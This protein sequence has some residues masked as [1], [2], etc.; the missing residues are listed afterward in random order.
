MT[1]LYH[2]HAGHTLGA[3]LCLAALPSLANEPSPALATSTAASGVLPAI[4]VKA[5]RIPK[6]PTSSQ[7]DQRKG[8]NRLKAGETDTTRLIEQTPGVSAYS[9]GGLSS[10]PAIHGLADD[11]VRVQV[12]GMD[13]QAACPNHMNSALSYIAPANVGEI[14]VYAGITPVSAGGDSLGGSIQVNQAA[15]RFA[16][17]DDQPLVQGE[18][19][20]SLRS[21]GRAQSSQLSATY[22]T[23]SLSLSY[24]GVTG[25]ADNYRAARGFKPAQ[26]GTEGGRIIP[27]DEVASSAY[28]FINQDV[29]LAW[30]HD[31]HLLELK[32][33]EQH[34]L[35]EGFPNQRMDMTGNR[36]TLVNLHY[37]G[38]FAWGELDARAYTQRTHHTMDMGPDRYQYGTGM[39]MLTRASTD[40]LQL[41]A[42]LQLTPQD[43]LRV[44]SEALRYNLYDWWP[45]VGGAMGPRAFWNIDNG[46]RNR[47]GAFAEWEASWTSQWSSE[48]GLRHDIVHA[49][50][51]AVQGYDNG[52]Q[53]T[54]GQDAS[55]FNARDHAHTDRNWDFVALTRYRQDAHE[56]LELAYA[57]KSRSP[58]LY[59]R[60]P[61]S[62]QPMAALMNNYVGDGNGYIG[63]EDLQPEVAHTLS[64]SAQWQGADQQAWQIK[65]TGYATY[66]Q[67]YIDAQRCHTGQCSPANQTA[68]SGFVLLQYVNQGARLH[69]LDASGE[70][71]LGRSDTWG[72]FSGTALLNLVHGQNTVTDEPLYNI[73]P[74]NARVGLVHRLA[75]WTST[76]ELQGVQ[77]KRRVSAVRNEMQTGGYSLVHVKTSRDWGPVQLDMGI[78]NVF[79]R[80]YEQPLGGAYVGQGASMSTNTIPWG[81]VVPGMGRAMKL[82]MTLRY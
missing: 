63:N 21:N 37:K 10:L 48:L 54:W 79:N 53:A 32:L 58:S 4:T 64:A 19:G 3:L 76:L 40:G 69:G 31:E 52:L 28:K 17:D 12:D 16:D 71:E 13:L 49:D 9:A 1:S 75:G 6:S 55:A 38:D 51:S 24:S 67:D 77:G 44:G 81:T 2:R 30:Q 65:L 39:P 73:M 59:Q 35:F 27:A 8:L 57:R 41:T 25:Q 42:S 68:T 5:R 78:D 72:R 43:T 46:R 82:A 7:L 50:T 15:P 45:P 23:R 14:K 26:A 11:R 18:A 61:W 36:N 34:V 74:V 62:T 20:F 47:L 66:I 80:F 29:K 60:Y 70:V 33:G 22:A 56:T